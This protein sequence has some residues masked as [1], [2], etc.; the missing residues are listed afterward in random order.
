LGVVRMWTFTFAVP[1]RSWPGVGC[2]WDRL[3][4]RLRRRGFDLRG[5]RVAEWHP[6]G[7]GWHMHWATVGWL[8]IETVRYCATSVGW[9]SRVNVFVCRPGRNYPRYLAKH[10]A[11]DRV[12]SPGMRKW[13]CTGGYRGTLVS[14]VEVVSSYSVWRRARLGSSRRLT[15]PQEVALWRL[16]C[17]S[18]DTEPRWKRDQDASFDAPF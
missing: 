11:K 12:R 7:H 2:C 4:K 1:H 15:F 18:V 16:W 10:F 17:T 9:G 14:D 3:L 6:G 13:A 8:P 5:V